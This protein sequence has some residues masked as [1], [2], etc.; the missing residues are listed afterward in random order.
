MQMETS[1]FKS[2]I[3][4][5]ARRHLA[6]IVPYRDRSEHLMKFVPHME[7]FLKGIEF[8]LMLIEQADN[9]SFNRGKLLNIGFTLAR[10]EAGWICFHDI[11]MLPEDDACDYSLPQ[12]TTHLAG[13]VEQYGYEMPSPDYFGGVLLTTRTDFERANGFSNEYWGW[14]QEDDDLLIRFLLSGVSIC[15]KPGLYRSLPHEPGANSF[16]NVDRLIQSLVFAARH[17]DDPLIKARIRQ[18]IGFAK[19]QASSLSEKRY[20]AYAENAGDYRL[21]GLSTLR[22]DLLSQRPLREFAQF[23]AEISPSHELITV[24][25]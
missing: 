17:V 2:G 22:Y 4:K 24:K 20:F 9:K 10:E 6:L 5:E 1:L 19:S 18:G 15:R 21:E 25:L 13:R 16:E 12:H 11:D 23:G 8:R 7:N 3:N 14:G